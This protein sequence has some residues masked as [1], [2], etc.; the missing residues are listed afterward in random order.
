MAEHSRR[1][2]LG[3]HFAG[4]DLSA[5]AVAFAATHAVARG[6]E[7]NYFQADALADPL[8]GDY[9][10]L[11]HS[12]FLHHLDTEEALR[13]LQRMGTA[14][15]KLVLVNDLIRSPLGYGLAWTACRLLSRSAIV[16]H[17]GPVSVQGAFRPQ[18]VAE[19]AAKAGLKGA[20]IGRCW[21]ER[22]LL[23]WRRDGAIGAGA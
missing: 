6:L 14:A 13:L 7:V 1:E 8:P 2:G 15:S 9:D 16:H 20:V 17:D 18:E 19:L 10:V 23:R 11:L 12:L 21:P 5:Q 3:I 4:C 22:Y